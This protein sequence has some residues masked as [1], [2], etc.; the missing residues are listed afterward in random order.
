MSVQVE[1]F[2]ALCSAFY[3]MPFTDF[4]GEQ[5]ADEGRIAWFHFGE[6]PKDMRVSVRRPKGRDE[7]L[8]LIEWRNYFADG[9]KPLRGELRLVISTYSVAQS[10]VQPA[11]EEAVIRTLEVYRDVLAEEGVAGKIEGLAAPD[12]HSVNPE[13]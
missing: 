5:D 4:L 12:S 8:V 10:Q 3:R 1:T 9:R 7:V 11:T 2:E 13:E 6:S